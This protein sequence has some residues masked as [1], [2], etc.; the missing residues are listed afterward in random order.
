MP[1]LPFRLGEFLLVRLFLTISEGT[2]L[3]QLLLRDVVPMEGQIVNAERVGEKAIT[4]GVGNPVVPIVA[5]HAANTDVETTI[6]ILAVATVAPRGGHL[7][8]QFVNE[9]RGRCLGRFHHHNSSA[10]FHDILLLC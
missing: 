4:V 1:S 5:K 8:R 10:C 6:A 2:H 7:A 3:V 9:R